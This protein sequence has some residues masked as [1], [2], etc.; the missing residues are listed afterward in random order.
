M[1]AYKFRSEGQF[2]FALDVI[3]GRRL[4]C[5]STSDFNDPSEGAFGAMVL[6]SVDQAVAAQQKV[7]EHRRHLRV[8]SLSKNCG[9]V[10]LWAYYASGFTGLAIAVE[11]PEPQTYSPLAPEG[12]I[13][14]RE[15]RYC[16]RLH[17]GTLPHD[18]VVAAAY[19]SIAAKSTAWDHEE[20]IRIIADSRSLVDGCFYPLANP[21]K[22]IVVGLRFPKAR[23]RALSTICASESI[24]LKVAVPHGDKVELRDLASPKS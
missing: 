4:Y 24:A 2:D 3:Y 12:D 10:L 16:Q 9:Q 21:V 22:E 19:E 8:C 11:I 20:E 15:I 23:L 18:D 13:K 5:S 1:I 14:V 6:D 7:I 17:L